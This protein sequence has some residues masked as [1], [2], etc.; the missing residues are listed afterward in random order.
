MA[1]I[2]AANSVFMIAVL[3]LFPAPIQIQGFSSDDVFSTEP[4]SPVETL[5]GVDGFLSGGFVPTEKK[6]TITLQ[7]DSASNLIFEIWYQSQE[8]AREVFTATGIMTIPS[9]GRLYTMS[10]G[11]LTT[12]PPTSDV[13]RILQPRR[14]G[15]TWQ[16]IVGAPIVN[17]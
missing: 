1:T 4:V 15:I 7:A 6:Q 3:D 17:G 13:R 5:M 9:I 10:R 2:T 14:Y 16:S 8:I 12:F 11:F